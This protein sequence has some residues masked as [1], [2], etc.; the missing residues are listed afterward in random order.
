MTD[1]FISYT[2]VDRSWAEWI[3]W[4]LQ[5]AGYTIVLQAWHFDP[6]TSFVQ[7]MHQ[8]SMDAKRTIAV[9]SPDYFTARFT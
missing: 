9:L 1:F 2:G 7:A 5:A 4:H 8:A 6:G 3:A